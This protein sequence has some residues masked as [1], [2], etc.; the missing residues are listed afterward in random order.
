MAKKLRAEIEGSK[1]QTESTRQATEYANAAAVRAG[2]AADGAEN[3]LAEIKEQAKLVETA[4]QSRKQA[5]TARVDAEQRGR[6]KVLC[7]TVAN[8]SKSSSLQFSTNSEY[9]GWI[10]LKSN[11][12]QENEP[13]FSNVQLERS[14]TV[15]DYA[16][17]TSQSL[18][19]TLPAEHPYL[20]KL[21]DGTA[22]TIEVDKNG[23]V[24]LVARVWKGFD[25]TDLYEEKAGRADFQLSLK[26]PSDVPYR[27]GSSISNVA[28]QGDIDIAEPVNGGVLKS[29]YVRFTRP[30]T[31]VDLA[32]AKEYLRSIG[33]EFYMAV[34]VEHTYTLGKI[35][36]PSLPDSISNV[37]T[38]AEVTPKTGIEHT[39]DVNIAFANI[40]SAIASITEG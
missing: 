16:P 12:E 34:S 19:F 30:D 5:E 2:G 38:D 25:F 26:P 10:F 21:P 24:S 29:V 1:A 7:E 39:R 22:D 31:V 4:E 23:N 40:E 3:A 11:K 35:T 14:S 17:Y 36:V 32:T 6:N 15:S 27:M 33:A 28:V 18:P 8:V 9:K 13:Q 37:W 20:A